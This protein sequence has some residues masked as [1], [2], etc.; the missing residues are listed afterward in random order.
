MFSIGE[1]VCIKI[2]DEYTQNCDTLLNKIGII[3]R[4]DKNDNSYLISFDDHLPV[5]VMESSLSK[6]KDNVS[7]E[8]VLEILYEA[9]DGEY[10]N[11][12]TIMDVIR[13]VRAL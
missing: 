12:G 10:I 7:K 8:A 1:T 11:Y 5:W 9:K 2:L 13:R 4:Y 6:E 3:E